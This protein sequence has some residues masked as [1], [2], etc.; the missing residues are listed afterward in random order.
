MP[1]WCSNSMTVTGKKEHLIEFVEKS[2][3]KVRNGEDISVLSI[4]KLYPTPAE[5]LAVSSPNND[6]ELVKKFMETYGVEDWWHWR[7]KNW[8]TKWELDSVYMSEMKQT[9]R[10]D[11]ELFEIHYLFESAWAPPVD[12]FT[13]I[14]EQFP[15]LVFFMHFEEPGCAF[16]GTAEIQ[17]SKCNLIEHDWNSEAGKEMRNDKSEYDDEGNMVIDEDGNP[18]EVEVTDAKTPDQK[19][20]EILE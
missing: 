10:R 20:I 3:G 17:N 8:G 7:V 11:I 4:E 1:N 6:V 14:S 12:A 2:K 15:E 19:A 13:K 16:V 5:L 9:P 18:V